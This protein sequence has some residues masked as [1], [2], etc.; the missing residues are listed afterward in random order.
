MLEAAAARRRA[1]EAD[2]AAMAE[3]R[4]RN[5]EAQAAYRRRADAEASG[6][7]GFK[8][9]GSVPGGF[10]VALIL[11]GAAVGVR[12]ASVFSTPPFATMQPPL[13]PSAAATAAAVATPKL[14]VRESAAKEAETP[15]ADLPLPKMWVRESSPGVVPEEADV[16]VPA[17]AKRTRAAKR[18]S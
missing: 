7:G 4:A 2:D 16:E 15:K 12:V 10:W 14:V 17:A 18:R 6:G 1:C 11:A 8:L 5:A 13:P 9:F 3:R